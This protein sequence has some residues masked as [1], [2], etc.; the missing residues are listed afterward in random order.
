MKIKENSFDKKN[1]FDK[2]KGK[3]LLTCSKHL[4]KTEP[5]PIACANQIFEYFTFMLKH[6]EKI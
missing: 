4:S 6:F 5:I 2:T 1:N 3:R